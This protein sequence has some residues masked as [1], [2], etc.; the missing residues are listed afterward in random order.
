MREGVNFLR[1]KQAQA[2]GVKS[3]FAFPVLV[4]T[5]VVAVLEFFSAHAVEVDDQL[6]DVMAHVGAQLGREWLLDKW[7][8]FI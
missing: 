5:E 7:Y 2:I 4:G 3:G 6:L 8:A 1:A